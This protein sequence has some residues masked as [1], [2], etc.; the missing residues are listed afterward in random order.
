MVHEDCATPGCPLE[1][2]I[3]HPREEAL[4]CAVHSAGSRL[5]WQRIPA[6]LTTKTRKAVAQRWLGYMDRLRVLKASPHASTSASDYRSLLMVYIELIHFRNMVA[7][8]RTLHIA[9]KLY[10]A[11]RGELVDPSLM[12]ALSSFDVPD[13]HFRCLGGADVASPCAAGGGGG[14]ACSSNSS[15]SHSNSS[16]PRSADSRVPAATTQACATPVCTGNSSASKCAAVGAPGCSRWERGVV[17]TAASATGTADS[18]GTALLHPELKDEPRRAFVVATGAGGRPVGGTPQPQLTVAALHPMVVSRCI[19]TASGVGAPLPPVGLASFKRQL[20]HLRLEPS[21]SSTSLGALVLSPGGGGAGGGTGGSAN[22]SRSSLVVAVAHRS[23]RTEHSGSGVMTSPPRPPQPYYS[24]E[25]AEEHTRVLLLYAARRAA[26][27]SVAAHRVREPLGSAAAPLAD[28]PATPAG[29][30]EAPAPAP[31]APGPPF[32]AVPPAAPNFLDPTCVAGPCKLRYKPEQQARCQ[33][34]LQ[35]GRQGWQAGQQQQGTEGNA[36]VVSGLKRSRSELGVHAAVAA[37]GS[38]AGGAAPFAHAEPASKVARLLPP[39]LD[40]RSRSGSP[41][42]RATAEA[43]PAVMVPADEELVLIS[44]AGA[45]VQL[46]LPTAKG[47]SS[48]ARQ[49]SPTSGTRLP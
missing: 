38:T 1:R 32:P 24:R 23:T 43:L 12:P 18:I 11:I 19:T 41:V 47:P 30:R 9:R 10:S 20:P 27:G 37:A 26:A 17:T 48:L 35:R 8:A 13:S 28:A 33:A 16:G 42:A 40:G 39:P 3:W 45:L 36:P 2:E 46:S 29:E 31:A 44:V 4:V 34:T 25:E 7:S 6:W 5:F 14:V 21:G 15:S 49:L 22:A